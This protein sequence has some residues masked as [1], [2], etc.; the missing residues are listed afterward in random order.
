MSLPSLLSSWFRPKGAKSHGSSVTSALTDGRVQ[1]ADVAALVHQALEQQRAGHLDVA[2]AAYLDVLAHSPEQFD[3]LHMLGVIGMQRGLWADAQTYIRRALAINNQD[4]A[5]HYNL[6]MAL[7]QMGRL[8]D[9][10]TALKSAFTLNP[11]SADICGLLAA[12]LDEAGDA[13]EARKAYAQTTELA[14]RNAAV[15]NNL[16]AYQ[17][18]TGEP[19]AAVA[20]FARAVAIEQSFAGA[21]SNLALAHFEL[22]NIEECLQAYASRV[23]L[24]GIDAGTY[25]A[26]GNA[27]MAAGNSADAIQQYEHA[28]GLDP[29]YAKARWASVMAQLHPVNDTV[30]AIAASRAAF[31]DGVAALDIWFTPE[32][33]AL[34][35]AAIGS[36]QPFYLAYHAQDNVPLLAAYGKLCARLMARPGGKGVVAVAPLNPPRK[37]RIGIAT[38]HVHYHSV[39]NA[40]TK[41]WV[42]HL[43]PAQFEVHV[44]HLGRAADEQTALARREATDFADEPDA[45]GD[46]ALT[47]HS[48]Q[49][50]ALIYPDIGMHPL[51]TQLAAQRLAPVQAAS[52]GHPDTTGLPTID[53]FLSA[54][55]LEAADA[56]RYYTERLVRLPH[57]GVC[58]EP[59]APVAVAPDLAAL[60]LPVDGPL[61]LCPGQL[62]KYSPEHDAVWVALARRLQSQGQGRM[63]FFRSPRPA[64]TAQFERRLR[65]AFARGGADFDATVSML[66][67]L[68][69]EQF[70]GLM[71][72]AAL[73]LDTI[74]FSGFNTALQCVECG[75]PLVAF[76]G[77]FMRGRLASGLLRRLGLENWIASTEEDFIDKA[78]Q[79]TQSPALRSA[80]SQD[81]CQR[82]PILFN[83]LEPVRALERVLVEAVQQAAAAPRP[84]P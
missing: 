23:A 54:D 51:T 29:L 84:E 63:V 72:H 50:D 17:K 64:M 27:C 6:G 43:D 70:Y 32:R 9:A 61:L 38:A 33:A 8:D 65:Q 77:A 26:Y 59:L 22:G 73:M 52:W 40:I 1:P 13:P 58:V 41:G 45:S 79:L 39:W 37:L 12:S 56:D 24:G 67:T 4:A 25:F 42:R 69:P 53:V 18:K 80:L 11:T 57:L 3:A 5:A 2:Q 35:A 68:P 44:F 14:P 16:G 36:T 66:P 34:G 74:G 49:L 31:A 15:Y 20:S 48:A 7:R 60:G 19:G 10:V 83:D 82:R 55:L 76:E 46:W 30:Q 28:I 71:Q 75:L 81:I 62:F 21:W 47:I 78:L